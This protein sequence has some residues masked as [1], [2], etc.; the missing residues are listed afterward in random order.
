M[1]VSSGFFNSKDHDRKYDAEQ[2][3]GLFEGI[4][5]DGVYESVGNIFRVAAT[6]GMNVT[7]DTGRAWFNSRWTLNDA[8]I[9]LTVPTAEQ[10]L[11]RIDAVV[12]EVNNLDTVRENAIKIIKGTPGSAPG[13][14]TLS[15]TGDI[16]QYPLAYITVKAGVTTITQPD[17]ENAVGTSEC[18]FVTGIIKTIDIDGLILQWSTQFNLMFAELEAMIAQAASQT[19]LDKSVTFPKLANDAVKRVVTNKTVLVADF[20][21]DETYSDYS[22]RAA[23]T[24]NGVTSDMIPEVMF[25]VEDA[26]NGIYAPVAKTYDGGVY[27]YA[28]VPPSENLVIPTIIVW[29]EGAGTW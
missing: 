7:V 11:D 3:S 12:L 19:L 25:D 20:V 9:V 16:Y 1:A 5:N 22:Y 8:L 6:T 29:R 2:I 17:I 23:I 10:V 14:P 4:I 24:I 18:P 26:I 13:K 21:S 27:I 28:S 15:K